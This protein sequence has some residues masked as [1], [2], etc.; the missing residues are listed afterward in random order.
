M[1]PAVMRFRAVIFDLD[2]TLLDTIGD[3]ARSMN[4]VLGRFG[5]PEHNVETYKT[6]VGDGME[7][8]VRRSMPEPFREDAALRARCVDAM[9]EEYDRRHKETTK[10][11]EGIPELLDGLVARQL[12]MAV[13]SNKPDAPTRLLV[14]ELL[15]HWRFEAVFGE[16]PATPRKPNPT[17]ALSIAKS[18]QIPSNEFLYVGDTDIDMHTAA[19]AG[20]YAVGVLWGFRKADELLAGGAQALIQ[21]P[22]EL[23][24]FI[25]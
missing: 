5:F 20:M 21:K 2:G 1:M 15:P 17:G 6:Y 18:L 9:R 3:L 19:A 8:L 14:A 7:M 4:I 24:S 10:P 12:R 23:L 16:S 13:L 22:A 25:L 11:Y